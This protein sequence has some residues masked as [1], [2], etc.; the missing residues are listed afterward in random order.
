MQARTINQ[1]KMIENPFIVVGKVKPA[2]FCDRKEESK[3]LI[4]CLTNGGN[5]VVMS[6]RRVGKTQLIQYCFDQPKISDHYITIF[7]DILKT[8]SL[9][10]FIYELGKAVFD[11]LAGQGQKMLK[12]LLATMHSLT[13]NLTFNPVT[14]MPKLGI[15]IGDIQNPVYS[16]EEIFNTL[17][18]TGKKCIIAIDEFQQ[19]VNYP[20]KNIEALLRTYIQ[21]QN[22]TQ[23][24]FAGSERHLLEEMFLDAARPFYN[25]ADV[26][27]VDVIDKAK[28]AEFVHHHFTMNDK[29]IAD[30]AISSVYD[31]FAGNTY[32][33][34]KTFREAFAMTA[35]GSIC[36]QE[37]TDLVIHQM[38]MDSD[39]RY[40]EILARLAL[41]QKELLYAIAKEG[42]A[43]QITSGR[44]IRRHSL[45]SASSI[46]SAT[47][48]LLAYG[49]VST[50]QGA[51]YIADQLMG[52]WLKK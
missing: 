19:I 24:I 30:D 10:E 14:G 18:E 51:Y 36:T 44:F 17:A 4:R 6:P 46:Q 27:N 15:S 22:N 13:G 26:M 11:T 50:E 40:S 39:R 9:N 52:L 21:Q 38:V 47:K 23:F 42:R 41:P 34:Q 43:E 1:G 37:T 12:K 49:L 28:Y 16:L 8:S 45:K 29:Q 20:E 48:K 2:Y 33:N 5:I 31:T 3:R 35:T 25:S 7:I 32:Y